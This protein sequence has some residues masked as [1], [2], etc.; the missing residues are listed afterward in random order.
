MREI[1]RHYAKCNAIINA[2]MIQVLEESGGSA[3]DAV[4]DGFFK[5]V[6]EILD[7]TYVADLAW[8]TS[9][10]SVRRFSIFEDPIFASPP[11]WSARKFVD[12]ASFKKGR[13]QLDAVFARLAE[14]IDESDLF[15]IVSRVT[16]AGDRQEKLFWKALVHVFNHQTHHRGQV[17]QILDQLKIKNDYSNMIRID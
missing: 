7:H 11:D 9:F 8:L 14:E 15:G 10:R 17:S 2:D 6:G 1:F 16:R 12:L 13:T 3:Y 4:V 5:S